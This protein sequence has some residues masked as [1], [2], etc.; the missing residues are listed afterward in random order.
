MDLLKYLGGIPLLPTAN[1]LGEI[2]DCR[3]LVLEG[4]FFSLIDE[5]VRGLVDCFYSFVETELGKSNIILWKQM[6]GSLKMK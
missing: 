1:F 6:R 2:I 3:F 4:R 5:Q